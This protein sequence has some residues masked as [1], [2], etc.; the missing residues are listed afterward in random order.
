MKMRKEGIE[1]LEKHLAGSISARRRSGM[2]RFY[3]LS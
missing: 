3:R 2:T 1:A